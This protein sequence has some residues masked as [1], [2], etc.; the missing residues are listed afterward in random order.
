ML[1]AAIAIA[2]LVLLLILWLILGRGPLFRRALRRVEQLLAANNWGEALQITDALERDYGLSSDSP[3]QG[4]RLSAAWKERLADVTAEANHAAAAAAL[5]EKR[6]EDALKHHLRAATLRGKSEDEARTHVVDA[7][8]AEARRLFAA[9]TSPGETSAVLDML[10]RILNVQANCPEASFWYALCLIR[11]NQLEAALKGLTQVHGTVSKAVLDPALYIGFLLHRLG[12]AQEAVRYLSDANR[13]D[14]SCPFITWQMGI[15]LV[16]A[17]G[18]AGLAVRALQRALGPRGLLLWAPTPERV[19]VEAFP[20][21]RSYVRRLA[22]RYTYV[23]PLLGSDLAWIM[24]QGQVALAQALYRQGSFQEASELYARLMQDSAPTLTLLR[25]LGLSLARLGKHDQAY[26]HLLTAWKMEEGKDA[27]TAG[28]LA[29]CG[30]MGT[31]TNADDRPKNVA[32]AIRLLGRYQVSGAEWAGICGTIFAEARKLDMALDEEDQ[33]QCCNVLASVNAVDPR[34]AAAYGHLAATFPGAVVPRH[35][36]LYC[37]AATSHGCQSEHDLALFARTFREP[38][39]A[40]D[41]FALQ[42]W[43]FD[44]VQYTYLQRSAARAPGQFPEVL[45][46]A[47]PPEGESFLL[48]RSRREETAGRKDSAVAAAEVL[49]ELAPRCLAGYDRLACLNYRRGDLDKAVTLLGG[50]HRLAPNDHWPLVRQAIIE[51]ERG[52]AERR[53]EAIDRALGLTQGP[54]RAAIA[55][56]GAKLALRETAKE[57]EKGDKE[58][59]RQGDKEKENREPSVSLSPCLPVSLSGVQ[60]LLQECLKDDPDH[61]EALWCLAAVRSVMG[62]KERLKEQAA[63]MD[64]PGVKDARFHYLGAVCHLARQD[65]KRAVE[66]SAQAATDESLAAESQYLMAWAHLHLEDHA[67]ATQAL[68]KVAAAEKSPSAVFARAMLG[69]LSFAREAYDDAIKW[70]NQVD[71]RRRAEWKLDEPLRQT[72]FL[73]GLLAFEQG[74]YEQ[75]ADRIREAGKLGLRDKRLGSLL[76]LA[77]VKAGQKLLF[78]EAKKT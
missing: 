71:A 39:P 56:L 16:A 37:Q 3:A 9:G 50:W 46:P 1:Y 15:A 40:R 35:A 13:L 7:M 58:T 31:P 21:G 61:I 27:V 18:D 47:Y 48:E 77:L 6:F 62:D 24:R 74:R 53:A 34:A 59:R 73:A 29:L 43:N 30:A 66:L 28:Y 38:R 44:E 12:K 69:Q 36:W 75:A 23:C 63:A 78:E 17:G 33:V 55:F 57:W 60:T 54:L 22:S 5:K 51:Q 76:T 19:W 10:L 52:N 68:R 70:W 49:L 8:L 45:G 20:E 64:R 11:Q 65:Y 26:K 32:W 72:V 4:G 25:G 67:A 41:F 42:Q 14:P 2:A